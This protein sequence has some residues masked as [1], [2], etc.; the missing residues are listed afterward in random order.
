MQLHTDVL[1]SMLRQAHHIRERMP[2]TIKYSSM[3]KYEG[4]YNKFQ[5]YIFNTTTVN[6]TILTIMLSFN[7]FSLQITAMFPLF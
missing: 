4:R 1:K 6:H 2:I 5:D 7:I 3:F